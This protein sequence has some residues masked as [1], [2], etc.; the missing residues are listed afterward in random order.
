MRKFIDRITPSFILAY[1]DRLLKNT[2]L[3]WQLQLPTITWIWL[4][5]TILTLPIP[6]L[7]N[8]DVRGDDD[9]ES[10]ILISVLT[11]VL[12]GFLYVY[13]LIQFNNTKTFGRRVFL[14]GF[15]EQLAYLYVFMLCMLHIILYPLIIDIR[16]GDV[17]TADQIKKEA[18]IYNEASYYFMGYPS[19]Y[20]YFPSNAAYLQ[21]KYLLQ[22]RNT[23]ESDMGN[24]AET[25]YIEQLKPMM[26]PYFLDDSEKIDSKYT[27]DVKKCPKLYMTGYD[28]LTEIYFNYTDPLYIKQ[29]S[30]SI[31]FERYQLKIK[32]DAERLNDIEKFIKLYHAYDEEEDEILIDSPE[33][34][35]QKYKSNRFDAV[36]HKLGYISSDYPVRMVDGEYEVENYSTEIDKNAIADVHYTIASAKENKWNDCLERLMI[37]FFVGLGLSILLF[38][39]KNI[40]LKEF[41]LAFVYVGLLTLAVSILNVVFRGKE[42]FPIHVVLVV[43][44]LGIYFSFFDQNRKHFSSIKTIF[45]LLSNLT[46]AFAPAALFIYFHE[47]HDIGKIPNEYEYCLKHSDICEQHDQMVEL[48]RYSCLWGGVLIY[49]LLG[50]TLY[51]KIYERLW[52]LPFAK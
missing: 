27:R 42:D 31:Y 8:L 30:D 29:T 16:K 15:K 21:Y 47:Y 23:D 52:A 37:C 18:I 22:T 1:N 43:F 20:R 4:L 35:L 44:F 14:N 51:K 5:V 2:P 19:S 33:E 11:A 50:S 6:L 38:V 45:I 49:I 7:L 17:M 13:I 12:S 9:I 34:I 3:G 36:V 26:R 40:R 41:I 28:Q 25:Y 48:I 24:R 39:F 46:I 32:S 10:T